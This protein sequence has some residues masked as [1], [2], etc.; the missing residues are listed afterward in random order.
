MDKYYNYM[1]EVQKG[2]YFGEKQI[3]FGLLSDNYYIHCADN[4]VKSNANE[5]IDLLLKIQDKK[6][7][8]ILV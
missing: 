3:I 7:M 4:K 1:Y 6:F 2:S 5:R 8:E